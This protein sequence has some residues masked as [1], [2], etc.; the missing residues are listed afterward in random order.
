[1]R[2][3]TFL[4]NYILPFAII[5]GV[6]YLLGW[7]LSLEI[8][9][10][11]LG[12][13]FLI[14]SAAVTGYLT[15]FH[16][17]TKTW[18]WLLKLILLG[19]GLA[20]LFGAW[21]WLYY[22]Q[23]LKTN[24]WCFG[25]Y[26]AV[27]VF[28]SVS[29]TQSIRLYLWLLKGDY[30]QANLWFPKRGDL[31]E[32]QAQKAGG[33]AQFISPSKLHEEERT[34]AQLKAL[35][36]LRQKEF[37]QSLKGIQKR[38]FK[39]RADLMP[40][41]PKIQSQI[42]ASIQLVADKETDQT[43]FHKELLHYKAP[44]LHAFHWLFNHSELQLW[45]QQATKSSSAKTGLQ[46][47]FTQLGDYLSDFIQQPS[48]STEASSLSPEVLKELAAVDLPQRAEALLQHHPFESEDPITEP[49]SYV[50]SLLLVAHGLAKHLQD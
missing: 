48:A 22:Y 35:E 12:S 27:G 20:G 3:W 42:L 37:L 40:I 19:A 8:F 32:A 44:N 9:L 31:D 34:A 43:A 4:V 25:G 28:L 23:D 33:I 46:Y 30:F 17:A 1:M 11:W 41:D 49:I 24:L 10:F 45:M 39:E 50:G 47:Y 2:S 16:Q 36:Y 7:L 6:V 26:A 21:Y 38:F 14:V 5:A 15:A 18:P 13:I 29:L